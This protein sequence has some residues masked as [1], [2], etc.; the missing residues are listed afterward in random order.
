MKAT[1]SR[2]LLFSF[3]IF[4]LNIGGYRASGASGLE[5]VSA[6]DTW[7][8]LPTFP[9]PEPR[10]GHSAIWSGEAMIVW[11]GRDQGSYEP[12]QNGWIYDPAD[13]SV[14]SV[15][16]ENAPSARADHTA[17]WTGSKMI[18]WGGRAFG[19]Q[20]LGDGGMYDPSTDTW[21]TISSVNAPSARAYHTA[22]WTGQVMIVWGGTDDYFANYRLNDGGIYDPE[23]N[24]WIPVS[25]IQAPAGRAL[26]TALWT[27]SKMII[28]GGEQDPYTRLGDGGLFDPATNS[29]TSISMI[30]APS[31]R[32]YHTAVWAEN[33]MLIWGGR[34][35][36]SDFM[37]DGKAYNPYTNTWS[38]IPTD[39][40]PLAGHHHSAVWTGSKMIIW[41]GLGPPSGNTLLSS[42]A[43]YDPS[44][45]TWTTMTSQNTPAPRGNHTAVWTGDEMIIVGITEEDE[46]S[47]QNAAWIYNLEH[48]TWRRAPVRKAPIGRYYHSAIW[49][50]SRMIIW[51]GKGYIDKYLND[52][53]AFDPGTNTWT[54]ISDNHGLSP[55][56]HHSAVWTGSRMIIWGG[57]GQSGGTNDGA[58]YD[59]VTDTWTPISITNAPYPRAGHVTVWTG[60]EMIVWGGSVNWDEGDSATG[61][62]YNPS[63]DMWRS[64]STG[65]SRRTGHSAVWTGNAMI[66]WGGNYQSTIMNDGWSYDPQSDLWTQTSSNKAPTPRTGHAAVWTGDQMIIWG[67]E[68]PKYGRPIEGGAA[69]SPVLDRWEP[70][71]TE[72]EPSARYFFPGVWTGTSLIV[73]GGANYASSDDQLNDGMIYNRKMNRWINLSNEG[74]PSSRILHSAV[75][76]GSEYIVWGGFDKMK[77]TYSVK[78]YLDTGGRYM[79][80]TWKFMHLPIIAKT[81]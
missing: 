39:N 63:L 76:T 64:I 52:G 25:S 40:A 73:W 19:S 22:V 29:W 27:G 55:R 37:R 6:V 34:G 78:A 31:G 57:V 1:V 50:G 74:A 71:P 11:G 38:D 48:D 45:Q 12:F 51:G 77:G 66:L 8:P 23:T 60:T 53:W 61:G 2:I 16:V 21:S 3:L 44:S 79:P 20:F 49:T 13:D 7:A 67:G 35:N 70:L 36:T 80:I 9:L 42:G 62:I 54:R 75:W 32:F 46:V 47:R 72:N 30:N 28:W 59:P 65:P 33:Q 17:V 81:K 14:K 68:E 15:A 58:S 69:Y 5:T 41:G 24:S 43:I 18:V 10:I 56:I 4:F 26:H